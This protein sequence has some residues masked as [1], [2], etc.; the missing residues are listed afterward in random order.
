MCV[1]LEEAEIPPGQQPVPVA[2]V[3]TQVLMQQRRDAATELLVFLGSVGVDAH[4]ATKTRVGVNGVMVHF[5][6]QVDLEIVGLPGTA[7]EV[8]VV[9]LAG[10]FLV[11]EAHAAAVQRPGGG[12]D[13]LPVELVLVAAGRLRTRVERAVRL[14]AVAHAEKYLWHRNPPDDTDAFLAWRFGAERLCPCVLGAS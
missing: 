7:H 9:A 14:D 12:G 5:D 11:E 6:G 1:G 8:G 3:E 4:L 2:D 10:S 13:H